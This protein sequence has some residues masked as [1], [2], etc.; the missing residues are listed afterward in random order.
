MAIIII[1]RHAALDSSWIS[2]FVA[3]ILTGIQNKVI[4]I[5]LTSIQKIKFPGIV[6]ESRHPSMYSLI[7]MFSIKD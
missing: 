2:A 4:S 5:Q 6:S 3:V 1:L 7:N